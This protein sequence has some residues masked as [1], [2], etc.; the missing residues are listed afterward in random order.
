ME[1]KFTLTFGQLPFI[2]V[3]RER[4]SEKICS[5]FCLDYPVSH[6]YIISG[7][8][9]SGKTVLL[10]NISKTMKKKSDWLVVD[11]NPNREILEQIASG[12]YENAGVKHLFYLNLFRFRFTVLGFLL[13]GMCLFRI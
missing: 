9:E 3:D 5:N 2:Y 8:M 4:V 12:I 1:E 13:K 10:T 6:I 11:V 7:V